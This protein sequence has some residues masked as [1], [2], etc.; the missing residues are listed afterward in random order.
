MSINPR[1]VVL[2]A[3]IMGRTMAMMMLFKRRNYPTSI[4]GLGEAV[5]DTILG[6]TDEGLC[7]VK[8]AGRNC[9]RLAL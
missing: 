9:V 1:T 5:I 8:V 4:R 3:G 7:A 2:L 6:R